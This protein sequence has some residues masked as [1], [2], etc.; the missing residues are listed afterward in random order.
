MNRTK[1][2]SLAVMVMMILAPPASHGAQEDALLSTLRRTY[3]HTSFDAARRSEIPGLYEVWMGDNVAYVSAKMPRYFL[4][5]HLYDANAGRDLTMARR[6]P[7]PI[8]P[9]SQT[10]VDWSTLPLAD[11]ITSA[12]GKGRNVLVVFTDPACPYCQRLDAELAKL[13]DITI[14]HFMVP[15]LGETLPQAVWCAPDRLLAYKEAMRGRLAPAGVSHCATPLRRNRELA[16]RLGVSGTPTLIFPT[17]E[18]LEGYASADEVARRLPAGS[19]AHLAT[20]KE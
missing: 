17:G 16:S 18:R 19:A 7:A 13:D 4:F 10:P 2:L 12:S 20:R 11:A 1:R 14:H 3:P 5:G 15:F 9:A 8:A 6:K